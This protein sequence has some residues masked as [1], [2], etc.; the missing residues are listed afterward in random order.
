MADRNMPG[1][2]KIYVG[3]AVKR[4]AMMLYDGMDVY[5]S[6]YLALV[7]RFT[8]ANQFRPIADEYLPSMSLRRGI[9]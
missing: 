9:P 3:W 4:L 6:Y 1:R 7:I 2:A 5:F 8:T